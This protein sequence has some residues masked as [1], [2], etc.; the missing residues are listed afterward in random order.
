MKE[1][2]IFRLTLM[3]ISDSDSENSRAQLAGIINALS[4]CSKCYIYL[5]RELQYLDTSK[6]LQPKRL[7]C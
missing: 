7:A 6:E 4:P 5:R 3:R 1:F 2:D